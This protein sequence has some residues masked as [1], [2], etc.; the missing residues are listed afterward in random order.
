MA[1]DPEVKVPTIEFPPINK[2]DETLKEEV[3]DTPA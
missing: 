3:K 2:A 1:T